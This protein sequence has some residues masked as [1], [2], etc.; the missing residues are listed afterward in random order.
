M[1]E[2]ETDVVDEG[3]SVVVMVVESVVVVVVES[4]VVESEVVVL[5][6]VV[7]LDSDVEVVVGTDVV[8]EESVVVVVVDSVVAVVVVVVV[9]VGAE[10]VVVVVEVLD[11]KHWLTP[12]ATEEQVNSGQQPPTSKHEAPTWQLLPALTCTPATDSSKTALLNVEP[13]MM[14]RRELGN[15]RQ[16]GQ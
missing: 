4:V 9:V 11:D 2:L 3:V 1:V 12:G 6:S 13:L 8:V 5:K 10:V 14:T 16:Q 15:K 7:V